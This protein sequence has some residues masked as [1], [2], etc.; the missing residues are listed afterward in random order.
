MFEA[1]NWFMEDKAVEDV[2]LP[3]NMTQEQQDLSRQ[4]ELLRRTMISGRRSDEQNIRVNIESV[5]FMMN[6]MS[7]VR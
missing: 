5:A 6:Y 4:I 3:E 7:Q 1:Y 2:A